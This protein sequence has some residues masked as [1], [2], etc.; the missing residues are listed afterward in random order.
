MKNKSN[1]AIETFLF[2]IFSEEAFMYPKSHTLNQTGH[3]SH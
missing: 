3:N 2:E 1:T